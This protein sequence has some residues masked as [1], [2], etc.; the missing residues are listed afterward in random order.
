MQLPYAAFAEQLKYHLK[1][2][3]ESVKS[4]EKHLSFSTIVEN[5][6]YTSTFKNAV[7]DL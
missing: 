6:R 1:I 4:Y 2:K 3:K 7:R 5:S